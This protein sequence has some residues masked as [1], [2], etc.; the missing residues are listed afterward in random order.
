MA[1]PEPVWVSVPITGRVI[2]VAV[3]DADAATELP[4][5]TVFLAVTKTVYAVPA[6]RDES[7]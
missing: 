1:V 6:V 4:D 5:P 2:G 7:V 3:S